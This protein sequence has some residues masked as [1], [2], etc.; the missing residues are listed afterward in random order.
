MINIGQTITMILALLI[1]IVCHELA[2][3]YAAYYF[4]DSTA[5]K[6]GRLTIN[7]LSH[8]DPIGTLS[9][10]LFRFGWAKPVPVNFEALRPQKL[11]SIVVSVAGV[12][13]N[14]LLATIAGFFLVFYSKTGAKN[15]MII[16]FLQM[17]LI[18]NV[19]FA[20]FNIL[21]LPPLDGS[22]VLISLLPVDYQRFVY[23]NER[24]LYIFLIILIFTRTL[25]RIIGPAVSLIIDT[26][27][28]VAQ[29]VVF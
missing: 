2:H 24:Y 13:T 28:N 27:I 25:N 29:G 22:K 8:L 5:K 1:T 23:N 3:G 18:Y 20:V 14:L 10:I 4:G 17:M 11:G 21:P 15:I 12:I 9:M 19:S 26:I 16:N 7:P 6:A